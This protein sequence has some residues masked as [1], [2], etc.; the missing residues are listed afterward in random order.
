MKTLTYKV[1][2]F[3]GSKLDLEIVQDS[4]TQFTF[5]CGDIISKVF[6]GY[7]DAILYQTAFIKGLYD[8]DEV[9]YQQ[10]G[11]NFHPRTAVLSIPCKN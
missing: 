7:M 11:T 1:V 3:A 4:P 5:H 9:F 8:N 2:Y 6:Q 10:L